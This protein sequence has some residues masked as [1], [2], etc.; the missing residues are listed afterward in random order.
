MSYQKVKR[1]G[2]ITIPL[3]IRQQLDLN[4]GDHILVELNDEQQIVITPVVLQVIPRA[5]VKE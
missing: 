5:S 2:Q 3:E 1:H 4:D